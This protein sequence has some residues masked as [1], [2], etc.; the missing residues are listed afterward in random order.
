VTRLTTLLDASNVPQPVTS[1]PEL[2]KI[3]IRGLYKRFVYIGTGMYFGDKDIPGVPLANVSAS[4][5][6][7]IYGLVDDL[8]VPAGIT[9]VI[10][11]LR[12]NLVQQTLTLINPAGC[13]GGTAPCDRNASNNPIDYATKKGWYMDLNVTGERII[14]NPALGLGALVVTSNAPS[15]DVCEAGGD[16]FFTVIDYQTGGYKVGDPALPA[17]S[18]KFDKRLISAATLVQLGSGAVYGYGRLSDGTTVT[19]QIPVTVGGVTTKRK[20]W[21]ELM[22]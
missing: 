2:A 19:V 12:T 6:N 3:L 22:M 15:S 17:S 5:V 10:T 13:A 4:Q 21:R 11:P 20:S 18:K 16:A 14:A 9:S 8:S 1:E 7:S